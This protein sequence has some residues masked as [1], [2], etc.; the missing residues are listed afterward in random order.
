ML[1]EN[2]ILI[3]IFHH[4]N[5]HVVKYIKKK[6]LWLDIKAVWQMANPYIHGCLSL[7]DDVVAAHVFNT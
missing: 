6:D 2:Y 3:L 7:C 5:L 4:L 1:G